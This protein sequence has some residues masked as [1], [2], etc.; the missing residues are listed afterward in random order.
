[1]TI[2]SLSSV[3]LDPRRRRILLRCWRRGMREIDLILGPFA[4][5]C[6]PDLSEAELDMLEALMEE[7]DRDLWHWLSG[8]AEVPSAFDTPLFARIKAFH[9]HQKPVHV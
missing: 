3:D 4:D 5:A 1:M 7:P 8:E 9:T 6:L 2:T